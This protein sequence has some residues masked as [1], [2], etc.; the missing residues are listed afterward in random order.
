MCGHTS[1]HL[2][3]RRSSRNRRGGYYG[4]LLLGL[5]HGQSPIYG[6]D[7][8]L[9][10]LQPRR[11]KHTNH[12]TTLNNM[13]SRVRVLSHP[14][15][16][17]RP[18]PNQIR[19]KLKVSHRSLAVAS[20]FLFVGTVAVEYMWPSVVCSWWWHPIPCTFLLSLR[21]YA[22]PSLTSLVAFGCLIMAAIKPSSKT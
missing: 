12:R 5:V 19:T 1:R 9:H 6:M 22:L 20:L 17:A 16:A 18:E 3:A 11:R 21:I 14:T 7:Q 8:R 13:V 2:G 15:A 10:T 4:S